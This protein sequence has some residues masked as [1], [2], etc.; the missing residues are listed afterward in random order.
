MKMKRRGRRRPNKDQGPLGGSAGRFLFWM[1]LETARRIRYTDYAIGRHGAAMSRHDP[2]GAA[3]SFPHEGQRNPMEVI[4]P[5]TSILDIDFVS[6]L[7]GNERAGAALYERLKVPL[8]R[9]VHR[10]ASD[11]PLDI[12]EDAVM[13]VFAVM[14]EQGSAFDPARGSAQA[15]VTAKL[16][17]EAVRRVRAENARPGA[18]KRQRKTGASKTPAPVALEEAH[19]MPAVGYGSPAA[20][21]AACDAHVI[22][23]WATPSVRVIIGGLV[24]GKAQVDIASEMNLDRFK[25][26]R[27][28][29]TMQ[30]RVADAA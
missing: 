4:V 26:G 7:A 13:E 25:V 8:L 23:S 30:H 16:L 11:L 28:I 1:A 5:P 18:P 19:E 22:W 21:E 15:F 2:Q 20:M 29:K 3:F 14:M 17:P 12:A 6:F 9:Q 27:M 10:Y 24:E